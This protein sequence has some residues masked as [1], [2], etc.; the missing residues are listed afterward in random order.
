MRTMYIKVDRARKYQ[1]QR[2]EGD[3]QTHRQADRQVGRKII[4]KKEEKKTE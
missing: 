4:R 1:S 2:E 3:W